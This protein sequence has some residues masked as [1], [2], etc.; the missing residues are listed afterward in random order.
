M[1]PTTSIIIALMTL[2]WISVLPMPSRAADEG[3]SIE[4]KVDSYVDS[5]NP[6]LDSQ[7]A[8]DPNTI[9]P[10]DSTSPNDLSLA[11][12]PTTAAAT[13]PTTS[14]E[15]PKR[16]EILL[17]PIPSN[18]PTFGWGINLMAGYIFKL[19]MEDK[20]SPPSIVAAFG[21]YSENETWVAGGLGKFFLLE[22]RYRV[23]AAL[24]TGQVNYDFSGVGTDA[25]KNGIT[26]PLEQELTAGALEGLTQIA[27][28]LYLGPRYIYSNFHTTVDLSSAA[29]PTVPPQ[30]QLD[31]TMSAIGIHLQ[32]DTRDSQ[33]YPGSG[34]LLDVSTDFHETAWGDDFDY[35]IYKLSY[36]HYLTIGPRQVLAVRGASQFCVGDVPFYSLATF[37]K[38]PDLRG[39]KYGQFQDKTLLA[40][41]AEYRLMLTKRFGVVGFAGVGE[42][43]PKITDYTLDDILPSI[44][45]GLRYVLAEKN[46]IALR[47]DFAWGREGETYYLSVG[48]AF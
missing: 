48:E 33:F 25:G 30:A 35:Q 46:H 16:G 36:N 44:G 39:Y 20:V 14:P 12:R 37:G 4:S 42:I 34:G 6:M 31:S 3:A 27:P 18:R 11:Q 43:G 2:A 32:W 47:L 23:T 8:N 9:T 21:Y 41:Q 40:A 13:S 45:G 28:H 29:S 19:D 5:S 17:V 10:S 24:I 1:K 15:K 38:G 26:V 22:D 7:Y